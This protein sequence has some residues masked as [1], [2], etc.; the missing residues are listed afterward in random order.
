GIEAPSGALGDTSVE[1]LDHDYLHRRIPRSDYCTRSAVGLRSTSTGRDTR[2]LSLSP[3]PSLLR[4][5]R[6]RITYQ[7]RRHSHY[8]D[9]GLRRARPSWGPS[10]SASLRSPR[11]WQPPYGTI[12]HRRRRLRRFSGSSLG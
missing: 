7:V 4:L 1:K 9:L 10:H 2:D 11:K 6:A 12:L 3:F 8:Q 5:Q